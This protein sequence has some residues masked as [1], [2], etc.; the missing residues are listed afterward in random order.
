MRVEMLEKT[1]NPLDLLY[2]AARQCYNKGSILD[3]Y[4]EWDIS[5]TK[6]EILVKKVINS[7]HLSVLEHVSISFIVDNVSRALTHQLVRHRTGKYSQQSQR[8]AGLGEGKNE[9]I[10]PYVIPPKIKNNEKAAE[11][12]ENLHEKILEAYQDLYDLGVP[13]EDARFV[14]PNSIKS[15]IVMT[16]DL[17][18]LLHFFGERC[19]SCSQWEIRRLAYKMLDICKREFPY[20]F[21]GKGPK[22]KTLGYCNEPSNR[23][24]GKLPLK[25]DIFIETKEK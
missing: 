24:C 25:K 2:G 10:C 14:L 13:A 21:N 18:N 5:D 12:F 3:R 19:C 7:G 16:M 17:R 15:G 22:C 6:K 1:S 9:G 8:Y 11:I 20:V 23:S 4:K